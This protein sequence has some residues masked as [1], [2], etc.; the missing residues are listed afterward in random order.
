[1]KASFADTPAG[2]APF[3]ITSQFDKTYVD[4]KGGVDLLT[5]GPFTASLQ[6]FAQL[7][8][9]TT[10]YGGSAKLAYRF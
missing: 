6:G 2:V 10:S 9:T 8:D 7:S 5:K 4:V 3:T 1:M